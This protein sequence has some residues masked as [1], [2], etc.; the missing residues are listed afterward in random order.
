MNISNDFYESNYIEFSD[1]RFCLWDSVK[2]FSKN[3]NSYSKVLDAGC[4]NGKNIN[5]FKNNCE[6]VGIDNCSNFIKLC[7]TNNLNVIESDIRYLPFDNNYFDF[8][9]SIAVIHHFD[10]E[11]DRENSILEMIRVLKDNGKL[12][13]TVWAYESDEYSSKKK[14]KLGDNIIKWNSKTKSNKNIDRY[15]YIYDKEGIYKFCNN[16][17]SKNK[18]KD[19]HIYWERGNWVC[20]F[21]K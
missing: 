11:L 6:I 9:M 8:V 3:F 12:L 18:I 21:L 2:D 16:I 1:T 5:Y 15:Y 20:E 14:F 4:G 10:K 17:L 13:F 19:Y 7:K